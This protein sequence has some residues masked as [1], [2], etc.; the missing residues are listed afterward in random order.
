VFF[1]QFAHRNTAR[2]SPPALVKDL[3]VPDDW[4]TMIRLIGIVTGEGAE[5][6]LDA[7]DD[8][9]TRG[10]LDDLPAEHVDAVMTGLGAALASPRSVRLRRSTRWSRSTTP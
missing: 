4:E 1:S 5:A 3:A 9:L 10:L 2:Y 8:D 7:L 6:D